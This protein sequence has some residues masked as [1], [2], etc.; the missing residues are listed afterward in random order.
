MAPGYAAR[1][2]ILEQIPISEI[3]QASLFDTYASGDLVYPFDGIPRVELSMSEL[4]SLRAELNSG[5]LFHTPDTFNFECIQRNEQNAF[6]MTPCDGS[7]FWNSFLY[8]QVHSTRNLLIY[9][10]LR[11]GRQAAVSI[12]N[13]PAGATFVGRDETNGIEGV[14]RGA[15]PVLEALL[16]S[17]QETPIHL[18]WPELSAAEENSLAKWLWGYAY[19]RSLDYINFDP[20]IRD[21]LGTIK[22]IRLLDSTNGITT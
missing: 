16:S 14:V 5:K 22:E 1:E 11:D 15:T 8:D 12:Q 3:E 17:P 18:L 4:A 19:Q 21:Y 6:Q 10:K 7:S 9:I 20:K 2:F 13:S